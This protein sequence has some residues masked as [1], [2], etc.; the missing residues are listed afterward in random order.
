MPGSRTV[1][2]AEV[3]IGG[4][5]EALMKKLSF[6]RIP[7][8]R[9]LA[10]GLLLFPLAASLH[11]HPYASGITNS[12]GTIS[13]I[14]NEGADDVSVVFDNGSITNDFGALPAGAHVF[15][16]S[17]HTNYTIVVMK[18]GSGSPAQISIDGTLNSFN[19]PRG[20]AVNR[21]PKTH[22]FGRI[23]VVNA[24]PGDNT[25]RTTGRGVYVL[26]A[27]GSDALGY[28]TN[29]NP[30]IGAGANQIQYGSSTT[31]GPYLISVGPDDSVYLGDASGALTVGTTVGGGVWMLNPDLTTAKDLFTYDGTTASPGLVCVAGTPIATG[32]VA[33][34]NLVLY[35]AEWNR[36][37]YNNIWKYQ[38][39]GGPFPWTAAPTQLASAG[40]GNINEVLADLCIAPDGKFFTC[41][42]RFSATNGNVSLRVF[43]S[44]G[45]TALW[46]SSSAAGGTDPFVNSYGMAVSPD[47]QY[48]ATGTGGGNIDLCKLTNGIPDL[49]TF[50]TIAAGFGGACRSVA[51]DAA[52]NVYGTSGSDDLLRCFSMGLSTVAKT[53]N[54]GT[55]TNGSFSL[56]TTS[57]AIVITAQPASQSAFLG[58][59]AGFSVTAA[60]IPPLSYHWTYNSN[61]LADNGHIV[62]SQTTALSISGVVAGD[63]GNY[64]VVVTN[65]FGAVTS[66]VATLTLQ[67]TAPTWYQF[68]N[69]PGPNNI[70][71][72][73]IY[74]TDP[75]NGWASQNNNI[76][77]TTDGGNTW[78]T[79][80]ASPGTHFRSVG[81]ATPLIGFAGNLGPGSY[82]GGVTD[83][84][85]LYRTVDGG[86]TWSNVPGFA[87]AGMKG[88]C[89]INVL[90]SQHIY[91][92]GRVRGPAY[93]IKSTDG[94]S[95]W[96]ILS[97]TAAGVM[98]GIMDV[99]FKDPTNGWVVGMDT[100]QFASPPYYGRIARTT[101]G[102]STWT[103]VVTTS[104]GSSYFWKMSWPS[105]NIGYVALQQNASFN[106][107]V[108]YKTTN[109]GSS[110]FSNSISLSGLGL[111]AS[112]FYLQGV[113]FVSETEGWIGGAS[114]SIAYS[115]SF[116]H[117][118]DGGVTWSPAG[119]N[120]TFLVNR[121]RFMSP[122][123]GWASG[124]NLYM[125]TPPLAINTQPQSQVVHSG[126]N[127]QLI[128][129]AAGLP[130]LSYQWQKNGANAAGATTASLSLSSVTRVDAG[131]YSVIVSNSIGNLPS[132][133]AIVRVFV[134]ERF[135]E[136]VLLPGSI[137]QLA[138][139]DADGGALIT[140][141][142]LPSFEVQVTT[143][144][145]DWIV[146][147]NALSI[148]N[149][150]V[151]FQDTIT[152]APMRFYRVLEH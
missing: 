36:T 65:A 47:G 87:E 67:S 147:T 82:D 140:T 143:N 68:P 119:F 12:A 39:N 4:N 90:D 44:D 27:D 101:D 96:T 73:D 22:N 56:T 37:P 133:N 13:C 118:I 26:N 92:A 146:L 127:V 125:Y 139:A 134:P 99:Y 55:T 38:M 15:S 77:R 126:T 33:S 142:D 106:N 1:N 108:F 94:G 137:V 102:G 95:T 135:A 5:D 78:T 72:D 71:H 81:F 35:T 121:I 123:L 64:T 75:T 120:D 89:V 41:E 14:L 138:F 17:G 29:A 149:G 34:N 83:P 18:S 7:A 45:L 42:N 114:G 53:A 117:T 107:V 141:N 128:V 100:N 2:A 30:V 76:Y 50:T 74:F 10:F 84:N 32:S 85:V 40:I 60:G 8:W 150:T 16:L 131:V 54:D 31:Y 28:G 132:S 52:D 58:S 91:G 148:T 48:V 69:S 51:W 49:S 62:G 124:A 110:W 105:T 111:G 19:G 59:S 151:L 80:L 116:L 21:N 122:T 113:G 23:Y 79:S 9:S 93:F 20:V 63:L 104:I 136:P 152:N 66:A 103:P 25:V 97:L 24:S 61:Y 3:L 115:N 43:A 145:V 129:S 98:N 86:I 11:A 144:L 6:R 57:N 130:P 112:S 70:R 46:D 88:L 109:G